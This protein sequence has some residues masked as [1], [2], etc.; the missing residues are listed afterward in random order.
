MSVAMETTASSSSPWKLFVQH[1]RDDTL[2]EQV[3]ELR[4]CQGLGQ[5]VLGFPHVS[6]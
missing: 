4:V 5:V 2:A 6:P 1:A 3:V